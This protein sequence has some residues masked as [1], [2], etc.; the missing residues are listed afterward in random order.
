MLSKKL[1]S[2]RSIFS[3]ITYLT[4]TLLLSACGNSED[5]GKV[6]AALEINKLDISE[7][8]LSSDR[9]LMEV[10]ELLQITAKA[11]VADD[12]TGTVDIS[13]KVKWSSSNSAIASISSSGL[14]TGKSVGLVTITAT[15]A[16]LSKSI[17]IQLSDA[18]LETI[19]IVNI[20]TSISVCR[21]GYELKASGNYDDASV[22][23]IT[24]SV[25]WSSNDT[26]RLSIDE[27]GVLTSYKDGTAVVTATSKNNINITGNTTLTINDDLNSVEISANA[28]ATAVYVGQSLAFT[29]IGTYADQSTENITD[30]VEWMSS[31]ENIL[32]ISNGTASSGIALGTTVGSANISARCLTTVATAS[33]E[34]AISVSEEPVVSNIAIEEDKIILRFKIGDRPRQLS[35]RLKRTDDSYSTNV[36]DNEYTVWSVERVISG[37]TV[38]IDEIGEL[39]FTAIGI[40]EIKV[41]YYDT[42]QPLGPFTDTIEIEVVE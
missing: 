25:N 37:E 1:F 21:S 32:S 27:A 19:D 15:L 30:T 7:I 36:S 8:E 31:D 2:S 34:L 38:I 39:T 42:D 28:N 40:T 26:S 3:I 22:R 24:T 18:L 13:S 5:A 14:L 10:S 9:S 4:F 20:P 12:L 35:A 16:D 23:D 17:D 33:N 6:L 41:R 29:A 11:V